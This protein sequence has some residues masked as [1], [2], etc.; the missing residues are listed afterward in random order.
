MTYSGGVTK[1][2]DVHVDIPKINSTLAVQDN[3]T[4]FGTV[5]VA[6]SGILIP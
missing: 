5:D 1:N 2:T 3:A 4:A 6:T